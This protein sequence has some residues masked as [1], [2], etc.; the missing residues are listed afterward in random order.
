MAEKALVLSADPWSMVDEKTG[1][2]LSGNSLWYVNSYRDGENGQKPT[3]VTASAEIFEQI[4]G[5]LPAVCEMEYGSRPGAQGKATLTVVGLK[6][7]KR[8]DF[9]HLFL[10]DVLPGKAA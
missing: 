1:Q 10:P 3:K 9:S 4:K 7:L 8:I 2:A 6:V 5:K